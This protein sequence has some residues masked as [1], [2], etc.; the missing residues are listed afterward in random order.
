[1]A[2]VQQAYA[3][4]YASEPFVEV[5]PSGEQPATKHV[6]GSNWCCIGLVV[7]RRANQLI[8]TSV[9]DNLIKGLSGTALQCMN[10]M[11]GFAE[12]TALE[13]PAIWP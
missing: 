3:D 4:F 6:S 2:Q 7:D 10:L 5:L 1:M 11:L 12:T 13:A 9:I 8:I